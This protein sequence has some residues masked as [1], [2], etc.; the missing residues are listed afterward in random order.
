MC[1]VGQIEQDPVR[2]ATRRGV[3]TGGMISERA[4]EEGEE[5]LYLHADPPLTAAA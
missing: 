2:V 5:G 1:F 4:V 3:Q